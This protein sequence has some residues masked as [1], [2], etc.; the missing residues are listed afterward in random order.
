MQQHQGEPARIATHWQAAGELLQSAAAWQQAAARALAASRRDEE[1]RFLESAA[2]AWRALGNVDAEAAALLLLISSLVQVD[3]GER[4]QRVLDRLAELPLDEARRTDYLLRR[5]FA[6]HSRGDR[7]RT[8]EWAGQALALATAR[9]DAGARV[10]ASRTLAVGLLASGRAAEALAA[11]REVEPVVIDDSSV[12]ASLRSDLAWVLLANDR[13][14]EAQAT[15]HDAAEQH[16]ALGAMA[17]ACT[18]ITH[19]CAALARQGRVAAALQAAQRGLRL[20][21]RLGAAGGLRA[22]DYIGSA[23]MLQHLGHYTQALE[24][25]G[26][27][28][29]GLAA[30]ELAPR[31]ERVEL[32]RGWVGLWLGQ[33]ERLRHVLG[34]A[35]VPV[36]TMPSLRL[37]VEV[38]LARATG[39]A[40]MPFLEALAGAAAQG[41]STLID[42]RRLAQV[43]L[44]HARGDPASLETLVATCAATGQR[45]YEALALLRLGE[46]MC[47]RGRSG[48][49]LLLAVRAQALLDDGAQP[50][51]VEHGELMLALVQLLDA[52]GAPA[53]AERRARE[54]ADRLRRTA[55]EQVPADFRE[56]FLH[57]N[58]FNRRLLEQGCG[59]LQR[60]S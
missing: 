32:M 29:G 4:L 30:P 1:A 12:R 56:S 37:L 27:A 43:E 34:H 40:A 49:A 18:A 2:D 19:E 9:R 14:A 54:A 10:N 35:Q 59:R 52:A 22:L 60:L 6:E 16:L 20:H 41:G 25:Y 46:L 13:L 15:A 38:A 45:G 44:A 8:V 53:A 51:G 28:L 3:L 57:R 24:H 55:A 11:L 7:Q 17:S 23:L 26:S 33:P 5:A 50:V 42:H 48:D 36:A 58:A 47:A 31:R 39:R 21:E